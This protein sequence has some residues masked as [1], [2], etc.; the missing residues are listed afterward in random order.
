MYYTI[1]KEETLLF[2]SV[3]IPIYSVESFIKEVVDSVL[4]QDFE[5]F[6]LILVDDGSPDNCGKICDEFSY[7]DSRIKVIH[8]KNGGLGSARNAGIAEAKGNYIYMLD[9]DDRLIEGVLKKVYKVCQNN[10]WPDIIAANEHTYTDWNVSY[11]R[12]EKRKLSCL[13]GLDELKEALAISSYVSDNFYKKDFLHRA[14][15]GF[16]EKKMVSEDNEWHLYNVAHASSIIVAEGSFYYHYEM[17]P[18]SQMNDFKPEFYFNTLETW[19]QI[20][21]KSVM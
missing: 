21:R 20:D 13:S 18:G 10:N 7:K 15:K 2:F 4:K 19:F 8:K 9:G 16:T 11:K 5:D 3:I 17:R 12:K 6:E 1:F 14:N